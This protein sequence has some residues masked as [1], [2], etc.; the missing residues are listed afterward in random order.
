MP[1]PI[2]SIKIQPDTFTDSVAKALDY[3]FTGESTFV[4]WEM[5]QVSENFKLGLILGPSGSG[6]SLL[7]KQFG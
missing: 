3:T 7:L 4:G 1:R 5:P 2:Y 6:K